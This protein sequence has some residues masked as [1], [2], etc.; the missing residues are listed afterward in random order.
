MRTKTK[1]KTRQSLNF[2]AFRAW[3]DK[4]WRDVTGWCGGA[5]TRSRCGEEGSQ[6]LVAPLCRARG[7]TR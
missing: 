3:F 5:P 1:T 4:R 7:E 2:A 6:D